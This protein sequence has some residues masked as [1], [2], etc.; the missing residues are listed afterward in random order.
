MSFNKRQIPTIYQKFH[1]LFPKKFLTKL[2]GD[3]IHYEET[4]EQQQEFKQLT[5][6]KI[7]NEFEKNP[8]F[9]DLHGTEFQN[10]CLRVTQDMDSKTVRK[11]TFSKSLIEQRISRAR[12][13][14]ISTREDLDWN[15]NII[16][17]A[18]K[19]KQ[20]AKELFEQLDSLKLYNHLAE[21]ALFEPMESP[22]RKVVYSVKNCD[23]QDCVTS[24]IEKYPNS[25]VAWVNFANAHRV[26]GGYCCAMRG[27]QEEV[28]GSNGN[29]IAVLGSCGTLNLTGDYAVPMIGNRVTYNDG[30]HIPCGGNYFCKSKFLSGDKI[31]DCYMIASAFADFRKDS[32]FRKWTEGDEYFNDLGE[33]SNAQKYKDRIY[34]DIEGVVRTCIIEGIDVL[35]TGA[36]GCG[37]FLHDPT[38]ESEMWK[39]VIEKYHDYFNHVEFAVLDSKKGSNIAAFQKTFEKSKL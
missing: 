14:A 8:N 29:G 36:S 31:T 7:N 37:A 11:T 4:K 22:K 16:I 9:Y 18:D 30:F 1:H 19:K 2:S 24:M 12:F 25:K 28:V 39:M 34:L 3:Y 27:S 6:E 33:I 5:L 10:F 17:D 32:K 15:G 13:Y 20:K 21:D 26:G 38:L 35:V 23:T